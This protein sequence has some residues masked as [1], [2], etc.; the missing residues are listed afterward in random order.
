MICGLA[1]MAVAGFSIEARAADIHFGDVHFSDN[2]I[3]TST[4]LQGAVTGV[5]ATFNAAENAR[6]GGNT[7]ALSGPP[8]G[9]SVSVVNQ[10]TGANANIQQGVS[11]KIDYH[12]A[13]VE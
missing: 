13:P 4:V 3:V 7:L 11:V 1:L 12:V 6:Y 5:V 9:E 8:P 2:T 10:N